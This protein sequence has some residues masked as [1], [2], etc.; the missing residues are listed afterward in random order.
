MDAR[1]CKTERE[2]FTRS[3]PTHSATATVLTSLSLLET[4]MIHGRSGGKIS[5]VKYSSLAPH[6][7]WKSG[8]DTRRS[9]KRIISSASA[10]LMSVESAAEAKH[11]T[12][13]H[14]TLE[15]SS[16]TQRRGLYFLGFFSFLPHL[17][18]RQQFK[19][20]LSVPTPVL[21]LSLSLYASNSFQLSLCDLITSCSTASAEAAKREWRLRLSTREKGRQE[22]EKRHTISGKR[23]VLL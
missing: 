19:N 17:K 11:I 10:A 2:S 20:K 22:I 9:Q 18:D 5:V 6:Q 12:T 1:R 8:G 3:P 4:R 14:I 7:S 21:S 23:R 13:H 16:Q 15:R